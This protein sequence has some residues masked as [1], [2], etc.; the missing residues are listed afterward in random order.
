MKKLI[1]RL[2]LATAVVCGSAAAQPVTHIVVPFAAGRNRHLCTAPGIGAQ[3][4][5]MNVIVENKPGASGT[6]AAEY[7][8]RSKP[9]GLT[10]FVGTNS[11]MATTRCCST[12]CRTTRSRTSPRS[13]IS[14]TSR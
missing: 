11:T 9:D 3:Q 2:L 6:I 10:V 5:G 8:V 1:A 4:G 12:S 14:V 13:R 7:V